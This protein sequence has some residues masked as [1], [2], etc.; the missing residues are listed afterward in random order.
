MTWLLLVM[1]SALLDF[2]AVFVNARLLI[3]SIKDKAKYNFLQNGRVL[4]ICQ[5]AC[6]VTLLLM[7]AMY[8]WNGFPAQ[9]KEPC[10]F[11]KV[12]F[13]SILFFY[14]FNLTAMIIVLSAPEDPATQT[15]QEIFVNLRVSVALTLGCF[16]PAVLFWH[17]CFY[18]GYRSLLALTATIFV[19]V[20]FIVSEIGEGEE[21]LSY[22]T[23]KIESV[24]NM[25]KKNKWPFLSTAL[26]LRCLVLILSGARS[27]HKAL[28]CHHNLDNEALC[29][30]VIL[31]HITKYAV[32]IYLPM[33]LYDLINSGC[34]SNIEKVH[35]RL[36]FDGESMDFETKQNPWETT[37]ISFAR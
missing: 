32:G 23:S 1:I 12:V 8:W 31:S 33:K 5:Y 16:G 17:S 13:V 3:I 7:D 14:P 30:D 4:V 35:L 24:L 18:E 2:S 11:L 25:W 22:N 37:N 19:T 15:N 9:P 20:A 6:Q 21:Q 29:L 10:E 36:L 27:K 26:M 34:K 28:L